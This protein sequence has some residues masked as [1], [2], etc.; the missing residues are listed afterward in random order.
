[1]KRNVISVNTGGETDISKSSPLFVISSVCWCWL[2][3]FGWDL[4]GTFSGSILTHCLLNSSLIL[5]DL[6]PSANCWQPRSE[7]KKTWSKKNNQDSESQHVEIWKLR[8][9]A[10]WRAHRLKLYI[11]VKLSVLL[12]LKDTTHVIYVIVSARGNHNISR[13]E[14]VRLTSFVKPTFSSVSH[15][16]H[17]PVQH[18][19]H[20]LFCN[21]H[22]ISC[23]ETVESA[24]SQAQVC[25]W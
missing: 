3:L 9:W 21:G 1:M 22:Y 19:Q 18:K 8:L 2:W 25:V 11:S 12:S 20:S 16:V 13:M 7:E 6:W 10:G 4:L 14:R 17:H 24:L 5:V 23:R 15:S